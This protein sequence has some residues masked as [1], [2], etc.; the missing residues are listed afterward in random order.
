MSI[1]S[2][3]DFTQYIRDEIGADNAQMTAQAQAAAESF[4][5][6]Y[7][8]RQFTPSTG[9]ATARVYG[10]RSLT[11]GGRVVRVHDFGSTTGLIVSNYGTVIAST[12]YQL[13]PLNAL[14]NAGASVA[15]E[16]VRL[17][18]TRFI[19][20]MDQATITITAD[21][22]WPVVPAAVTEA[23]KLI[24]KDYVQQRDTRFGFAETSVGAVSAARNWPAITLL[25]PF[26]RP[27][28]FG[29]S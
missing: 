8:G 29:F 22:G 21:W 5:R 15:Y 26:R 20:L 12:A 2:P 19:T 18:W 6:Q 27:E 25:Q 9:S 3:A 17:F 7:C 11:E 4:V 10:P 23:V 1:V 14:N 28:A 16:Q 24:G 13:E